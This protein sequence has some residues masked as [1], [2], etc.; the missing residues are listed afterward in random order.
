MAEPKDVAPGPVGA[1]VTPTGWQCAEIASYGTVAGV[2]SAHD[3]GALSFLTG[4]PPD[5][6]QSAAYACG[7]T[8]PT[9]AEQVVGGAG[10]AVAS[11]G[12]AAAAVGS[13][14]SG[15]GGALDA[16]G[17]GIAGGNQLLLVAGG[18]IILAL[19]LRK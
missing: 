18:I 16:F 3:L 13:T 2:Y 5:Q 12:G 10:G 6:I 17:K 11:A 8:T 7:H 14:F 19:L 15:L 1:S 4:I 9:G